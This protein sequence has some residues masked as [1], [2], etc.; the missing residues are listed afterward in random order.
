MTRETAKQLLPIIEAWANG[1]TLQTRIGSKWVD[2]AEHAPIFFDGP[3]SFYRIKPK[4]R[5]FWIKRYKGGQGAEVSSTPFDVSDIHPQVEV[6][7]AR[8][9][10]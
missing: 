1:E 4:P 5:E 8:E 6:I 7:H 10:L 9:V 3:V 2:N